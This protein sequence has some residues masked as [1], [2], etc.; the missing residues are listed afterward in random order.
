V[1]LA[2]IGC[3]LAIARFCGLD[4]LIEHKDAI[5]RH[6]LQRKA[7]PLT[8]SAMIGGVRRRHPEPYGP[9]AAEG[10]GRIR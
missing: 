6:L 9:T 1:P 10:R 5:Y 8:P 4:T 7:L 3:I 2:R